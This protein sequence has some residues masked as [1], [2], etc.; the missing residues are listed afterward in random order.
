MKKQEIFLLSEILFNAKN[1]KEL[2]K[3]YI[4]ILKSIE[5][6]GFK[7]TATI[8]SISDTAKFGGLI[9]WIQKIN[10]QI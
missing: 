8:Y 7:N 4:K 10:Y 1:K 6:E 3:K 9:G 5:E 2:D